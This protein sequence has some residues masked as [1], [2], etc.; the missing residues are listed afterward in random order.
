MDI[1]EG[2]SNLSVPNSK[3]DAS[4][5]RAPRFAATS[6]AQA[7]Q[8]AAPLPGYIR[9]LSHLSPWLDPI[10]PPDLDRRPKVFGIGFHRSGTTSLGRALRSLGYRVNKGFSFNLPRKRV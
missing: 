2:R 6:E 4:P 8:P 10:L 5:D 7:R 1:S 3:G 9:L